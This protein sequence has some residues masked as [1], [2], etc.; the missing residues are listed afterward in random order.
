MPPVII[1][2]AIVG[3]ILPGRSRRNDSERNPHGTEYEEN[4]N[5]DPYTMDDPAF[6]DRWRIPPGNVLQNWYK[7]WDLGKLWK[8]S[9]QI[10]V[11]EGSIQQYLEV[12]T[13]FL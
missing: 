8:H 12:G 6:P 1:N 7:H 10:A 13:D 4:P 5:I 3:K 2:R 9:D 11:F